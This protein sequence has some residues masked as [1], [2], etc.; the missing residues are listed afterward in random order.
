MPAQPSSIFAPDLLSGQVCLV[1]G[2]TSRTKVVEVAGLDDGE[3][4]RR[5]AVL[6]EPAVPSG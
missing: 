5:I 3:L 2:A 6:D 1:S 4:S